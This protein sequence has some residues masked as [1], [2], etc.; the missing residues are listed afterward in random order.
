M[1]TASAASC[2]GCRDGKTSLSVVNG[3]EDNVGIGSGDVGHLGLEVLIALGKCLG[4]DGLQAKLGSLFHERVHQAFGVV[5]AGLIED[6]S[7]LG[8]HLFNGVVCHLFALIRVD[9]AGAE[10]V[11]TD[12]AFGVSRVD[13]GDAGS[14]CGSGDLRHIVLIGRISQRNGRAGQRSAEDSGDTVV[15]GEVVRVDSLNAV[16]LVIV[17]QNL[18]LL[19]VCMPLAF[20]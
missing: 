10:D 8:A 18:D 13:D 6:S 11:G 17:F 20:S 16:A 3:S 4:V 12:L 7:G 9:E 1:K 19:A 15:A 14:G 2:A 5:V